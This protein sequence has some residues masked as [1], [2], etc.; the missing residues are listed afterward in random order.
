MEGIFTMAVGS[1][2]EERLC[3]KKI[4]NSTHHD[5][6]LKFNKDKLFISV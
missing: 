1:R 3:H 5:D 2:Y 4:H 6:I